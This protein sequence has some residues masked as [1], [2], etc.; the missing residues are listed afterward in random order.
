MKCYYFMCLVCV[1]VFCKNDV[2]CSPHSAFSTGK[3]SRQRIRINSKSSSPRGGRAQETEK[4]LVPPD[5][6][7]KTYGKVNITVIDSGGLPWYCYTGDHVRCIPLFRLPGKWR[8]TRFPNTYTPTTPPNP[9]KARSTI[10]PNPNK[11]RSTIPTTTTTSLTTL[12]A[13]EEETT[14]MTTAARFRSTPTNTATQIP[15]LNREPKYSKPITKE[16]PIE[17]NLQRD[18]SQARFLSIPEGLTF[19]KLIKVV[20]GTQDKSESNSKKSARKPTNQGKNVGVPQRTKNNGVPSS[21]VK[22][23]QTIKVE[24]KGGPHLNFTTQKTS[25]LDKLKNNIPNENTYTRVNV[26]NEGWVPIQNNNF[27]RRPNNEI[28]SKI[29]IVHTGDEDQDPVFDRTQMDWI[30]NNFPDM[31]TKT[32]LLLTST[33]NINNSSTSSL[34]KNTKEGSVAESINQFIYSKFV[35]P[36][37]VRLIFSF[38]EYRILNLKVTFY[39]NFCSFTIFF[40]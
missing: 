11:A 7:Y 5:Y 12:M 36:N 30:R 17:S 6:K 26:N 23:K 39:H 32:N 40:S 1:L 8:T 20:T 37:Q 16:E 3:V 25:W 34:Q 10:P 38:L 22:F 24:D 27:V 13:P 33:F 19:S 2:Q 29:D 14:P 18:R 31:P 9:N 28:Q 4:V 35:K 21:Q 15:R